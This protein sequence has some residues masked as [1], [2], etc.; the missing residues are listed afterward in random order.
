MKLIHIILALLA[1]CAWG[2]NF[3]AGKIGSNNFQPLLFTCI[4]FFFLLLIMLPWL[5][6][7]R[8]YMKPLLKVAFLMGVCHFSMMFI[9]LN[10]G[11][12][13]ASIAIT[14]QLYVPFSA[15]LAAAFLKEQFSLIKVMAIALAFLGIL[16]IGFD[17]IVF[18]HLDA[19]LWVMGAAF[20]MA[21]STILMRQFPNMGVFRLQAWIA[22]IAT[23]SLLILSVLFESNHYQILT[24]LN[25]IDFWSPL[26]S[27]IGASVIGHGLVYYLL[28]RYPV[29]TVTPLMLLAPLLASFF[30]T[31]WFGDQNSWKLILGGAMTLTGVLLV[32]LNIEQRLR[33]LMQPH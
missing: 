1:N 12:N 16:V 11:A 30:G 28:A 2:F 15:I 32:S 25:I 19:V 22:L 3:I 17:P 9:G 4:R 13:I 27:A 29:S 18:N 6:P 8:G 31:W 5:R 7:T 14:A 23:P 20:V 33:R 24:Q 10:A 21:L 26:Y